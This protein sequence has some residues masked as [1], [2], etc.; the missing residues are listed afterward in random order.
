M[1]NPAVRLSS[2]AQVCTAQD[3]KAGTRVKRVPLPS[4]DT[5]D[6]GDGDGDGALPAH[7]VTHRKTKGEAVCQL[8][9]A[10]FVVLPI[11]CLLVSALGAALIYKVEGWPYQETFWTLLGELI[12]STIPM[13]QESIVTDGPT[14]NIGRLMWAW[15]SIF[16]IG[17]LGFVVGLMSGPL[18]TPFESL[19]E[20]P[21]FIVLWYRRVRARRRARTHTTRVAPITAVEA[22]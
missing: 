11:V 9:I 3:T 21:P 20:D 18:L 4:R 8:S 15:A 7:G 2:L 14:S 1:N 22:V 12:G 10:I 13:E 19:V 16:S 17:V 6:D 5:R